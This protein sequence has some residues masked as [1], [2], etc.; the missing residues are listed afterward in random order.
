MRKSP[1]AVLAI[2]SV[3]AGVVWAAGSF[4][5]PQVTV[6]PAH[7][8]L[9]APPPDSIVLA[10]IDARN[11][12]KPLLTAAGTHVVGHHEQR[13]TIPVDGV[14]YEIVVLKP[15]LATLDLLGSEAALSP[16]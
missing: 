15:R 3:A 10:P 5:G 7:P 4:H 11:Y 12:R 8:H 6:P 16:P 13:I 1:I 14:D 9:L 2:A